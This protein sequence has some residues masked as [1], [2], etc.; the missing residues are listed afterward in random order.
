MV[1][2]A[3]DTPPAD[4]RADRE[5]ADA[6]GVDPGRRSGP[7]AGVPLRFDL[8]P[9]P[10]QLA[11]YLV[12]HDVRTV[13]QESWAGLKN[14][15][16][17]ARAEAAGFSVFLFVS[18][19]DRSAFE[20]SDTSPS[21]IPFAEANCNTG[22]ISSASRERDRDLADSPRREARQLVP[23]RQPKRHD[24]GRARAI[25]AVGA[26]P[27]HDGAECSNR[28]RGRASAF[29]KEQPQKIWVCFGEVSDIRPD[30]VAKCRGRAILKTDTN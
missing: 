29:Q 7:L 3:G 16:L 2:G 4:P 13:Q 22:V 14:G 12:G 8:P 5:I 10:R 30:Q 20:G 1:R 6:G 18:R 19:G 27:V 26:F 23:R 9:L 15:E 25:Q 24:R 17:L 28:S 11:P 21:G